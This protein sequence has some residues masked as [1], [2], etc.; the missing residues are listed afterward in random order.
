[1]QQTQHTTEPKQEH[2]CKGLCHVNVYSQSIDTATN[3]F[4]TGERFY[5]QTAVTPWETLKSQTTDNSKPAKSVLGHLM[6]LLGRGGLQCD[7]CGRTFGPAIEF[8]KDFV[9]AIDSLTAWDALMQAAL[10][11]SPTAKSQAQYGV[12]GQTLLRDVQTFVGLQ[13]AFILTAHTKVTDQ[14]RPG[15]HTLIP[16]ATGQKAPAKLAPL[17]DDVILAKTYVPDVTSENQNPEPIYYWATAHPQASLKSRILP[18]RPKL[19]P[20]F[21]Q[22]FDHPVVKSASRGPNILLMGESGK[23]KTHALSTIPKDREG[24]VLFMESSEMTLLMQEYR[25]KSLS[26]Q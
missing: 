9:L 13:C 2:H 6:G 23:G 10:I 5:A 21:K 1:M 22:V 18:M 26:K 8:P 25:E 12:M 15:F 19:A 14:E 17:F 11:G 3:P 16:V 24:L 7:R 4:L 20:D